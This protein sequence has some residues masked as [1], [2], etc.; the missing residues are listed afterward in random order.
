MDRPKLLTVDE[1]YSVSHAKDTTDDYDVLEGTATRTRHVKTI[2]VGELAERDETPRLVSGP[3]QRSMDGRRRL[4]T[5][6]I[7][8]ILMRLRVGLTI[9]VVVGTT[10]KWCIGIR[11]LVNWTLDLFTLIMV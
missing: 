7:A 5:L 3:I 2:R 6:R 1:F 8:I 4:I 9:Q 11:F 10:R